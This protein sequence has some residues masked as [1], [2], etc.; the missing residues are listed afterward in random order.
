MN[1]KLLKSKMALNNDNN[2][3]LA[4]KLKITPSAISYKM[5]GKNKFNT[6]QMNFIRKEYNLSEVEFVEIFIK[7]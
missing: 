3:T 7:E 1:V 6:K 4:K 2:K 5:N